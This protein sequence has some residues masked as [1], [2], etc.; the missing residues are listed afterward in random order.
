MSQLNPSIEAILNDNGYS[1]TKQRLLVF[2]LLVANESLTISELHALT[3]HKIDRAS[4]Y[5][6]ITLFEAL[7]V[8]E[9]LN[10]GWKYKIELSDQFIKHHHHLTCLNCH[11]TININENDIE[12]IISRLAKK[13][14]F[15]PIKHQLEVQ[16]YCSSCIKN[17]KKTKLKTADLMD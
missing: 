10:I 12:K 13:H 16:G 17:S 9:R 4:L 11:R 5:R 7:G 15:K 6:A 3:K 1:V 2:E 14:K 8:V